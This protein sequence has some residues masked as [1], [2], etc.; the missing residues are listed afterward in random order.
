[1][2]LPRL[3]LT[4]SINTPAADG[5]TE[6]VFQRRMNGGDLAAAGLSINLAGGEESAFDLSAQQVNLIASRCTGLPVK[7]IE[8][9]DAADWLQVFAVVTGFF[10]SPSPS[11][12]CG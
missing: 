5:V 11:G 4:Q 8:A 3:K 10:G 6:I 7:C 9:V 2:D 12:A 1:M